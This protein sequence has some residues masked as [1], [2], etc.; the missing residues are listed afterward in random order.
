[1][2][3]VKDEKG[4][5]KNAAPPPRPPS[6]FRPPCETVSGGLPE[7]VSAPLKKIRDL[8]SPVFAR[9]TVLADLR[10]NARHDN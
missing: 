2:N 3:G 9:L 10:D 7:G 4:L 1:M 6:L 8:G 5:G